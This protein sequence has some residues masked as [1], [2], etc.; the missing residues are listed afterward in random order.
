MSVDVDVVVAWARSVDRRTLRDAALGAIL[1]WVL[2][3]LFMGCRD[4]LRAQHA[5]DWDSASYN[6]LRNSVRKASLSVSDFLTNSEKAC[7]ALRPP[8]P[9]T[10]KPGAAYMC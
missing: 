6:A 7:L 8:T 9:V 5:K 1:F 3:I 4:Q 2:V 10:P